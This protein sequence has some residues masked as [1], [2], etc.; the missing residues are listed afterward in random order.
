MAIAW[1]LQR[2]NGD[3]RT[4]E[5]WGIKSA[6]DRRLNLGV[7]TVELGFGRSDFLANLPFDSGETVLILADGD[8]YFRGRV[9]KE[10]RAAY[11]SNEPASIT[12]SDPWW[13]LENLVFMM[14]QQFV[15][16]QSANPVA[17]DPGGL[18]ISDFPS[19]FLLT[20]SITL[21]ENE[22]GGLIG[23]VAMIRLA[24]NYAIGRG[25][26]IA[27]GTI[28]AGSF[29]PREDL[30]DVTCLE[31]VRK[32]IRWTPDQTAWWDYSVDPPALNIRSRANRPLLSL[33]VA[34]KMI[35]EV[36]LNPRYDLVLTG[37]LIEYLRKHQ[38]EDF[39]FVTLD[40]EAAGPT[41]SGFGALVLTIEL[42]GSYIYQAPA[43]GDT[44][45]PPQIIAQEAAPAGIAALIYNSS[46]D[47][48]FDGRAVFFAT[49]LATLYLSKTLRVLNGVPLWAAGQIDIQ[50]AA[51]DLFAFKDGDGDNYKVELTV[52]HP[53]HLSASDLA[54]RARQGRTKQPPPAPPNGPKLPTLNYGSPQVPGGNVHADL[55]LY[56]YFGQDIGFPN[57]WGGFDGDKAQ[58]YDIE[59]GLPSQ[60]RAVDISDVVDFHGL[61]VA[62][63]NRYIPRTAPGAIG[64]IGP[65]L[66]NS[67]YLFAGSKPDVIV[68][69][70]KKPLEV[71]G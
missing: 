15:T 68:N 18:Q 34:D 31:V 60:I 24:V 21:A 32:S 36:E 3:T 28:D 51:I 63:V 16:N 65:L 66:R 48:S 49:D 30:H 25:A 13:Y 71:I 43:I 53:I 67:D 64:G 59:G 10:Q 6:I 46:K 45:P 29:M 40:Y 33:D 35:S 9:T 20:S 37:V 12:L 22:V 41:P 56:F 14:N 52:G 69:A 8:P 42:Y 39:E 38:R 4:F 11:G 27:I 5:E 61:R 44:A 17:A 58:V 1:T 70:W 26:P 7:G 2:A 19:A 57:S 23:S 55:I 50:E 54:S 62:R 47:L